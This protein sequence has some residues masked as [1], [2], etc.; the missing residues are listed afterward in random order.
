MMVIGTISM[1]VHQYV[2]SNLVIDV[3]AQTVG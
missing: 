2:K 1:V 3:K